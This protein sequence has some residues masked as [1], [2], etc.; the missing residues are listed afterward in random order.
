MH[1]VSVMAQP[2]PI[3]A[4]A[5]TS[6]PLALAKELWA[7]GVQSDPK[8]L[9]KKLRES[10]ETDVYPTGREELLNYIADNRSSF[11]SYAFYTYEPSRIHPLHHALM[12]FP[13][14]LAAGAACVSFLDGNLADLVVAGGL[15]LFAGLTYVPYMIR[16]AAKAIF[17]LR[18]DDFALLQVASGIAAVKGD[19]YTENHFNALIAQEIYNTRFQGYRDDTLSRLVHKG[20]IHAYHYRRLIENDGDVQLHD[21]FDVSGEL[22][23]D[24]KYEAEL[25]GDERA[26]DSNLIL[27]IHSERF[28]RTAATYLEE[29]E[30]IIPDSFREAASILAASNLPRVR[31]EPEERDEELEEASLEPELKYV[32]R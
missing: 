15:V 17:D 28:R 11:R 24:R 3:L 22:F 8:L 25:N 16:P 21:T 32:V 31:V 26:H 23:D 14:G 9:L 27:A 20:S 4:S 2:L 5:T 19:R 18:F 12:I 10:I 13:A 29:S 6:D 7:P 1:L 30:S